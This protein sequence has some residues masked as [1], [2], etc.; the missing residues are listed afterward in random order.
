MLDIVNSLPFIPAP[1]YLLKQYGPW[2]HKSL[3][4]TLEYCTLH[5]AA[6]EEKKTEITKIPG[7]L[8]HIFSAPLVEEF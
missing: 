4:F 1:A 8:N 7:L 3:A 6:S 5:F 2:T